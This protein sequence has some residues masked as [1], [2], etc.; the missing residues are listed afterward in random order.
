M[1]KRPKSFADV[2]DAVRVMGTSWSSPPTTS[3]PSSAPQPQHTS[4][5]SSPDSFPQLDFSQLESLWP[6]ANT[7]RCIEAA[8]KDMEL[9][10]S[11]DPQLLGERS[12]ASRGSAAIVAFL[13][14]E[15]GIKSGVR[16]RG[17]SE[18]GPLADSVAEGSKTSDSAGSSARPA[19]SYERHDLLRAIERQDTTTILEIRNFDFDLLVDSAPGG[20]GHLAKSAT[21]TQTPLGYAISLGPKWEPT[22]IVLVGALSKFVNTLPDDEVPDART[23][24]RLRKLRANLKLAID[25]SLATDQ[26]RLLS[27]YVQVLFMSEGTAFIADGVESLSSSIRSKRGDPAEEATQ[28]VL[29]FV[30]AGLTTGQGSISRRNASSRVASV[31]DLINNAI[32]DLL[33]MALWDCVR[34]RKASEDDEDTQALP[35]YFFARDDRVTTV[36]RQRIEALERRGAA[37]TGSEWRKALQV[38]ERLEGTGARRLESGERLEVVRAVLAP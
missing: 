32:G 22:A 23:L 13:A 35:A 6:D 2:V 31:Q 37:P 9:N 10:W 26:T 33:L 3:K 15:A 5:S 36:Y 18:A 14:R 16:A 4:T 1:S 21:L 7:R 12:E 8:V 34:P 38:K 24:S 17:T 29:R 27:S 28:M 25:S 19:R 30:N 20:S 11:L